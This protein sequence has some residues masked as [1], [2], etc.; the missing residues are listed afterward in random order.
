MSKPGTVCPECKATNDLGAVTCKRCGEILSKSARKKKVQEYD[1][2]EGALSPGCI[3]APIVLAVI[4]VLIL[5]LCIG[6]GPK[7]GTCAY[8]RNKVARAVARY[9][10]AN[11][12][13]KM[14][15]LDYDRLGRA[16]GKSQKP[17]LSERPS[18]PINQTATY[19]LESNGE[20]TCSNC[21][22]K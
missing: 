4:G 21:G 19:R 17:Y 14:N 2:T 6:G 18:C 7:P 10:R 11:P 3:A 13:S 20:V 1:P 15:T 5:Y 8:N 22:K 9:N 16:A 12:D